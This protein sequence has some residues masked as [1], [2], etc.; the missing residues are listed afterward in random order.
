MINYDEIDAEIVPLVRY[1]NENG[2]K[3]YMSCQ[4]H[5]CVNMSMLWV[6]FHNSISEDEILSFMQKHLSVLVRQG[7]EYN[8]FNSCGRF[9]QRVYAGNGVLDKTWQYMAANVNAA[10]ADL[11][12]WI[13]QDEM[14]CKD[15]TPT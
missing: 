13:S 9:V 3:T 6:E 12:R 11:E 2:L 1:F 15:A 8:F 5:S 10:N 7:K 14:R 4:G